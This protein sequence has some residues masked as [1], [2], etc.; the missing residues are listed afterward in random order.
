MLQILD[1][2]S[3]HF[4]PYPYFYWY[5]QCFFCY[6]FS[7]ITFHVFIFISHSLHSFTLFMV[8]LS[9]KYLLFTI[10][11]IIFILGMTCQIY[12]CIQRL[13]WYGNLYICVCVCDFQP[14]WMI[15]FL[16]NRRYSKK[17][18]GHKTL[19]FFIVVIQLWEIPR[20]YI[21]AVNLE[22]MTVLYQCI[23]FI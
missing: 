18:G 1:S 19:G 4:H 13:I 22:I 3:E 8:H 6:H 11:I 23:S 16:K 21:Y 20:K 2:W 17:I 14:P 5:I 9:K 15:D 10:H 12:L 7:M